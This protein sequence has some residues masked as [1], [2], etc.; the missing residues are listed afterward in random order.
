MTPGSSVKRLSCADNS[1]DLV[2]RNR[3]QPK[4]DT[5]AP[6]L[7]HTFSKGPPGSSPAACSTRASLQAPN[8]TKGKRPFGAD[9]A[10]PALW[11]QAR[12]GFGYGLCSIV[13]CLLLCHTLPWTRVYKDTHSLVVSDPFAAMSPSRRHEEPGCTLGTPGDPLLRG[14]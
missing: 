10:G 13:S 3:S 12:R 2:F 14:L 5:P 8:A 11:P 1:K 9:P 6:D 4:S 7:L